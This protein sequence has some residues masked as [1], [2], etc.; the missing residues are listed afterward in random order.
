MDKKDTTR[1]KNLD[2]KKRNIA[3]VATLLGVVLIAVLLFQFMK[4]ER[5]VAS[6]CKVYKEEKARLAKLPGDTW[7]SAVFNDQVGD[8]GELATSFH[9]LEEVSPNEIQS[10]VATLQKLYKKISDDPS[11]AVSA[12]LSGLGAEDAVKEWTADS[13]KL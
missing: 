13:C 6:Y 3:I 10:D 5:S 12:S 2:P 7:P 4:P 11:Q 1:V 9:Q 8:A